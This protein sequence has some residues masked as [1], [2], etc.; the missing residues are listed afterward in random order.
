MKRYKQRLNRMAILIGIGTFVLTGCSST[1]KA[2]KQ[3]TAESEKASEKAAEAQIKFGGYNEDHLYRFQYSSVDLEVLL[4]AEFAG[5][6]VDENKK[7]HKIEDED[8]HSDF[9]ILNENV[10]VEHHHNEKG[11]VL[12]TYQRSKNTGDEERKTADAQ[13]AGSAM[14]ILMG[15]YGGYSNINQLAQTALDRY[16]AYLKKADQSGVMYAYGAGS[17]DGLLFTCAFTQM[18]EQYY[19]MSELSESDF[20]DDRDFLSSPQALQYGLAS[21][22]SLLYPAEIRI[23]PNF[24][25]VHTD[26]ETAGLWDVV[27][28]K[29]NLIPDSASEKSISS[30]KSVQSSTESTSRRSESGKKADPDSFIADIKNGLPDV[31]SVKETELVQDV[32]LEGRNLIVEMDITN[33]N[34]RG[35]LKDFLI[36]KAESIGE[37]VLEPEEYDALWDRVTVDYGAV[38]R[39]VHTNADI[40]VNPYGGR[41]FS[42]VDDEILY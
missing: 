36:V 27:D 8:R 7:L 9:Y 18:P 38:G 4:N 6:I 20:K 28:R 15:N 23:D 31:L 37:V 1:P 2:G 16:Y 12:S 32:R 33:H 11:P 39:I 26:G 22:G 21:D 14:G 30:Q 34:F 35:P 41:Y 29:L 10:V 3:E 17:E 42:S 19:F 25:T 40:E 5:Q 24:P 13:L